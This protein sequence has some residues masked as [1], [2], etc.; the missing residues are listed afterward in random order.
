MAERVIAGECALVT[1]GARGIGRAVA[2]ALLK[3]GLRVAL[4]DLDGEAVRRT[5][6]ELAK[7]A[8]GGESAVRAYTLDVSDSAAFEA[9]VEQVER[10]LAPIDVLVN[11]A[12]IMCVGAF[13]QQDPKLDSRQIDVNLRGVIHGVRAVLPRMVKRRRGHVVNIASVVGKVATP[14]VTVYSA[15]K[16]AVVGLTEALRYEYE[17]SGVSF[18]YVLPSFVNTEL[19]S[20]TGRLRYPPPIEPDDVAN[21]VV[22]ALRYGLVDVYAPRFGKLGA[23]LPALLPRRVV[24]GIGRWFG[25]DRVFREVDRQ[26]R[27]AYE[28]RVGR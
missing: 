16:H 5:A 20:G 9:V 14:Y 11:N 25:V 10:E 7:I 21:A 15:T 3:E 13:L 8:P 22:R 23:V 2:S 26:R 18:S 17:D 24:E 19:I 4:T 6:D 1:G 12:G 28:E 27:A